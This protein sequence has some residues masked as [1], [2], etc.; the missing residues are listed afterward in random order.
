MGK[1]H[2]RQIHSTNHPLVPIAQH[3]WC[4]KVTQPLPT[5]KP[6]IPAGLCVQLD[7]SNLRHSPAHSNYIRWVLE[8]SKDL[9]LKFLTSW[10]SS[11]LCIIVF[12]YPRWYG[13]SYLTAHA[14]LLL[15]LLSFLMSFSHGFFS[16]FSE[17][18]LGEQAA[19]DTY[20]DHC[21]FL[22]TQW[23]S[24]SGHYFVSF[25]SRQNCD[26]I[27]IP[28]EFVSHEVSQVIKVLSQ[29]VF[30]KKFSNQGKAFVTDIK[31][32]QKYCAN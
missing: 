9:L 5:K 16:I 26:L 20:P 28:T 29:Q 2:V 6:H 22:S 4:P 25:C 32:C 12:S 31:H 11:C 1:G 17:W 30:R 23:L 15:L 24:H 13:F 10:F 18:L 27:S 21:L 3:L 19:I 8:V 7:I 14:R